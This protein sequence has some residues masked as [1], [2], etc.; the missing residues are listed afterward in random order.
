MIEANPAINADSEKRSNDRA[1]LFTIRIDGER[2]A[3]S[4]GA[5]S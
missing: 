3:S 4:I 2:Y 5:L 1:S